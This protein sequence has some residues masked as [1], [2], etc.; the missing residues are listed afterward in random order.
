MAFHCE[1]G[2]TDAALY[3]LTLLFPPLCKVPDG[4]KISFINMP[5]HC[6]HLL[7][8]LGNAAENL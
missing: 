7:T 5:L 1:S 2:K 6:G 4:E 3:D 8:R